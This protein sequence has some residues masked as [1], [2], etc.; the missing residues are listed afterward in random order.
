MTDRGPLRDYGRS[1]AVVM[2]T[3][4]YTFLNPVP[5]AE[6]SLRRM[7][8]LLAGRLCGWPRDRMLVLP[9]VPSP[10]DLPDQLITAFDPVTDAALFYFVGH[11]QLA[12]DDQLCLGLTQS[13]P[14]P[15]RRAAT[16]LRF[17]DVR[18]ALQDSRAA[19]KIVIL[20][21]CFAGQA[22]RRTL[23][24]L[25]DDVLGMTTGTGAY[26]MAATSAYG[27]AWYQHEPGLAEPQTYFTKYLADLVE[28]GIPG[29]PAWLRVDPL[30]RRLRD[31]LA[32]DGHPVPHSRA[33]DDAREF[34]FAYNAAPPA[35]H[36]DP[37]RELATLGQRLAETESLRATADAQISALQA[38]AANRER[39]L[40]RLRELLAGPGSRDVGQQQELQDAID[41]AAR[42]L[43]DTRAAQAAATAAPPGRRAAAAWA[44]GIIPQPTGAVSG[45]AEFTPEPDPPTAGPGKPSGPASVLSV[46]QHVPSGPGPGD[47][48]RRSARSR[49][50]RLLAITSA[51]VI[52]G[53]AVAVSLVL[54]I[55][56]TPRMHMPALFRPLTNAFI[57]RLTHYHDSYV[58]SVAFRPGG[59]TLAAGDNNGRVYLCDTA[60]KKITATL[61]GPPSGSV[62]SVAFAPRGTTLAAGDLDGHVDLWD[63]ATK[64][65]TATLTGPPAGACSRWRSRHAAPRSPPATATATW[66]CGTPPPRKSPPP[67]P[68][69]TA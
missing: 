21:C 25:A 48:R 26:T 49:R 10:G 9:N 41:Q 61:T 27:T 59:T 4:D 8:G 2:G 16:S 67:S 1:L 56:D 52:I 66:T 3:W 14:E 44:A 23:A 33:V 17:A 37:E 53:F 45:P 46:S 19:V 63:T 57:I 28:E 36:R 64:K 11:G 39:E 40:A 38:E 20:D 29:Q 24:G 42:Q 7:E 47:G 43:D 6:H 18:Q 30:F 13:R 50:G 51:C 58:W 12:P 55:P 60:T 22:T 69:P 62:L 32:A 35:T 5:A 31:N 68:T 34:V 54:A 15:N 65:I